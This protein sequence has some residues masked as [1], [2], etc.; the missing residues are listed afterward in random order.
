M[1]SI[2]QAAHQQGLL[3]VQMGMLTADRDHIERAAGGGEEHAVE[4]SMWAWRHL[5]GSSMKDLVL[6]LF[7]PTDG[8][9]LVRLT[10]NSK[11]KYS[12]TGGTARM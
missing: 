6:N 9:I 11:T 12:V 3:Y 8:I 1:A 4:V 2:L 10:C 5:D 7:S